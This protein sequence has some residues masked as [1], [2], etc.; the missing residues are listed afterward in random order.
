VRDRKLFA[1][2]LGKA[3]AMMTVLAAQSKQDGAKLIL[4]LSVFAFLFL[5]DG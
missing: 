3:R 1:T 2:E 4:S 5:R